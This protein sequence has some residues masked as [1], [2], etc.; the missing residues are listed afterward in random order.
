MCEERWACSPM[1]QVPVPSGQRWALR[2]SRRVKHAQYAPAFT[3][4]GDLGHKKQRRGPKIARTWRQVCPAGNLA[5]LTQRV[6]MAARLSQ[7]AA[8]IRRRGTGGGHRRDGLLVCL[9]QS[10]RKPGRDQRE[11]QDGKKH[12]PAKLRD[13]GLHVAWHRRVTARSSIGQSIAGSLPWRGF[14][15][16]VGQQHQ[17]DHSH[18]QPYPGLRRPQRHRP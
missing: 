2:R 8:D 18:A 17:P 11:G 9:R 10:M 5:G 1:A 16:R 14:G 13:N 7:L 6:G 12:H 4:R 15:E 3:R